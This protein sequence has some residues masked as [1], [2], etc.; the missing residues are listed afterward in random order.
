MSN[1]PGEFSASDLS[2]DLAALRADITRLSDTMAGLVR[3]Q[4][5][6]AS[7]AMK[8]AMGDA[9]DQL[10][11]AANQAQDS[12]LGAAADIERRIEKNPLTAVLIAAGIGIALGMMSK[13]RG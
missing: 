11:Q 9:R 10:S 1:K 2:A 5:N 7:V 3:G 13:S 8:G 4:A 6:S 12:A